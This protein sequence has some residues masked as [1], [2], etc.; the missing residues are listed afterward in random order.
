M[1]IYTAGHGVHGF[2]L[3]SSVGEFILSHPV[4]RIPGAGKTYSVNEG[5]TKSWEEGT[6]KYVAHAKQKYGQRYVGSLVADA[7]RTLIQGGIF[8]YPAGPKPKLRLL[9]EAAPMALVFDQ[10]G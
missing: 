6:R 10:A 3:D 9:Y 4:I 7:H 2:T 8:L 1:L 5:N